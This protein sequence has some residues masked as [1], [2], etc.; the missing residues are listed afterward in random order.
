MGR[1]KSHKSLALVDAANTIL[2]E[3]QPASVRAACYRLFTMGLIDSMSKAETNKVSTQLTWAREQALIPWSWIVDETRDAERVSA[4][5]NPAAY[6]DVVSRSY[7]RDRWTDQPNRIEVWSEKGTIRGT[8]AP[9][10]HKYGLTFRVMHGYGSSTAV[11]QVAEESLTSEKPLTV[12]Y[13]GDWDPSGLHMSEVDLPK[14]ITKYGGAIII[15]RLALS[16]TDTVPGRL[17]SFPA[18]TK[19]KDPRYG[20]YVNRYGKTCWEL[21]ALSPNILRQRV[22]DAVRERLDVDAWQRAEIVERAEVESLTNIL[23]NWPGI[24]GQASKY[25]GRA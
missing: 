5:E 18:E 21:D 3:I 13:A 8:L 16:T 20:W 9:V 24:S 17:P 4:W 22:E 7:R 19:R 2:Q 23:S 11:H 6:V 12:F 15:E 25:E 1:G 14:R 10:L